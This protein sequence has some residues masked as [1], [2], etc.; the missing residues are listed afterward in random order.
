MTTVRVVVSGRVQCVGFRAACRAAARER[1]VSG[2]VRNTD[3]GRVEALVSGARTGVDD[4]LEWCRTG[5][6]AARVDSVDVRA[7]RSDEVGDLP[8]RFEVR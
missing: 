6:R 5:P 1:S 3:D 8:E 2:W 4:L 7:V